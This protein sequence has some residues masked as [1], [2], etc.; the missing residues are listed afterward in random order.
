MKPMDEMIASDTHQLI[1]WFAITP[2]GDEVDKMYTYHNFV[3]GW[4]MQLYKDWA[5]RLVVKNMGN[6][7]E[8]YLWDAEYK[9]A[10]KI[11]TII[12]YTTQN[13]NEQ[14]ATDA[15]FVLLKTDSTVYAA[16]LESAGLDYGL[17]QENVIYSFRLIQK[18]WK[19]GET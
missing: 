5:P 18:D 11:L 17:T 13:R 16:Q 8:F 9:K 7:Y 14:A 15:Q 6:Q 12:A 10:E 4:Y 19:T 2:Q 3:G 1:R